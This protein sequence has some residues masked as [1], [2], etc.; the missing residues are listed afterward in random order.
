VTYS[1]DSNLEIGS[2]QWNWLEAELTLADTPEERSVRP[3]LL[4]MGHKPMYTAS[5]FGGEISTRGN[6]SAG[7]GTEGE[8]TA[9]LEALFVKYHVDVSFY[10]HIHSYNR[11]F[12]VKDDG[13]T[14]EL[15][16]E[17]KAHVYRSP[18]APVHM[19]VGMSG[20][21]HLGALYDQPAWSAYAEISYGWLKGTFENRTALRL[22][23]IANGD[24][25]AGVG[26]NGTLG[27]PFDNA[28]TPAVH[29]TVLIT[30]NSA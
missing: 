11:M 19:M 9:Q 30:K 24:G 10:G 13:A 12:P 20:A 21:G 16:A 23:F 6:P 8:L 4:L 14:V 1:T 27:H 17:T 29:D 28:G 7:E 15:T 25:A 5:T 26:E 2:E 3:W 22:D 18:S